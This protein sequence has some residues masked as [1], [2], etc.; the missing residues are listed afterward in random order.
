MHA[1][2]TVSQPQRP[3]PAYSGV[4]ET[5]YVLDS[6]QQRNITKWIMQLANMEIPMNAKLARLEGEFAKAIEKFCREVEDMEQDFPQ[7]SK[8]H[9][10]TRD[11]VY[12]LKE[13]AELLFQLQNLKREDD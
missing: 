6:G 11:V 4:S 9:L 13:A 12:H 3:D 10:L 8:E 7:P 2:Q 5:E 1:A